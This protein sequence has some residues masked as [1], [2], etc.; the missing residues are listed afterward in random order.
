MKTINPYIAFNGRCREAM[1]F[2]QQCFGGEL[3]LGEVKNAPHGSWENIEP[4]KILHSSLTLNGVPLLMGSDMLDQSGYVKGNQVALAVGC[5][6]EQ[7][8]RRLFELLSEKGKVLQPLKQE[9]WGGLFGSLED[10]YGLK[11]FLNYESK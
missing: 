9:F 2:Y 11:W 3:E 6:S 1:K 10:Q 4:D 8:I 7:D 5:S